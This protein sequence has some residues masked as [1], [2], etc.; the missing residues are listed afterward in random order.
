MHCLFLRITETLHKF[1][2][3]SINIYTRSSVYLR[4]SC[5]YMRTLLM[6]LSIALFSCQTNSKEKKGANSTKEISSKLV[7]PLFVQKSLANE[8]RGWKLAPQESWDDTIFKNYQ[9]DSSQINY[10]LADFNCDNKPDFA[11]ILKDSAENFSLFM[12]SS[13]GEYYIQ[14]ELER[15]QNKKKSDIGIRYLK[16]GSTF[17]RYDGSLQTFDCGAIES[18]SSNRNSKK[19]FYSNIKGASFV[20]E[21]GE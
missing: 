20:I 12:I 13:F 2:L 1:E 18:F 5:N 7:L 16:P 21:K 15:Y 9:T 3:L 14:D 17:Q 8:L 10:I 19:I 11:A 6:V 4:V